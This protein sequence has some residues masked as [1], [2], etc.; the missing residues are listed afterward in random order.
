MA[1]DNPLGR[2]GWHWTLLGAAVAQA[3]VGMLLVTTDRSGIRGD[4]ARDILIVGVLGIVVAGLIV[5]LAPSATRSKNVRRV[6]LGA[7]AL[8]TL[9]ELAGV[10]A[11]AVTPWTVVPAGVM[12]IG[13]LLLYRDVRATAE[14]ATR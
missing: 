10:M 12:I 8:L 1:V 13:M 3:V 9:V 7:V 14:G 6:M 4:V 5:V 2:P 11:M